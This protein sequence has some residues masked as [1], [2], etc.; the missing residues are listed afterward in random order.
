MLSFNNYSEEEIEKMGLFPKG[1]YRIRIIESKPASNKDQ[2]NLLVQ[3]YAEDGDTVNIKAYLSTNGKYML[4]LLRHF[5]FA[6]GLDH[7]WE[8]KSLSYEDCKNK[9]CL[10]DVDID[11]GKERY[12]Q[13]GQPNGKWDDKNVIIDWSK[14]GS[15]DAPVQEFNDTIPF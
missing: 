4:R 3:A 15:T 5:C 8:S 1:R 6:T 10:A 7:K 13:F 12:D 14:L 2:I 9:E 11:I